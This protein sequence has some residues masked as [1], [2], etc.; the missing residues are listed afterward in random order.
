MFTQNVTGNIFNNTGTANSVVFASGAT[1]VFKLGSNP[2]ALTAP[3]SRVLFKTGSLYR[4]E[5]SNS[6]SL[7]NRTYANFTYNYSGTISTTGATGFTCDD[8]TVSQGTLNLNMT[9]LGTIIKGN[10]SVASGATLTFTPATAGVVNFNGT[11]SQTVANAGTLSFGP[12]TTFTV[13]NGSGVLLYSDVTLSGNLTLTLG[14]LA[15]YN[16]TLTLSSATTISGASASSYIFPYG[17]GTVKKVLT[18][19]APHS[20]TFPLGDITASYVPEY[21]PVSYTLNSGTFTADTIGVKMSNT[22]H[23]SNTNT[24][25]FLSRN[26]TLTS[27]GVTSPNYD[28]TFDY[29]TSDVTGTES[30]L[31]GNIWNGS[32]WTV[33]SAVNTGT[34]A[35]TAS[36]QTTFGDYTAFSAAPTSGHVTVTVIPQ[37]YYNAGDYLNST[38]TVSVLLANASTYVT[39]DSTVVVLDSVTFSGTATFNTAATGSYYLVVKQRASV[40]TWSASTVSFVKGSTVSYDFTDAQT[41]AYGDNQVQVNSSPVR[42]AIYGGDCNQDGY[43]DPLDMSLIDQDSF[44]YV[45][46]TGLATDVNGDHFVDPLDMSIADQNSF[47]YVG[48]KRPVTAKQ[49][50]VHVR[51]QLGVLHYKGT[52]KTTK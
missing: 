14:P 51:P 48:I 49:L 23:A 7:S 47:N 32:T 17:A 5:S 3:S 44:N 13:N 39:V 30:S 50:N 26:W 12:N 1:F 43:V 27:A 31:N 42:W 21:T 2:F 41:K 4:H 28:A 11:S 6:P 35:F 45:S 37:G 33:L 19:A 16:S 15:L 29:L 20:F 34:H 10:V 40:E 52:L 18:G 38:D 46:G 36:A 24:S 9:A 25:N 22:K 8:L